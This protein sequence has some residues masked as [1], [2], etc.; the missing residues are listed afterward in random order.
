MS[1]FADPVQIVRH[2]P[3]VGWV[4]LAMIWT[5][6]WWG[7][8]I[9]WVSFNSLMILPLLFIGFGVADI[10]ARP[11]ADV[12]GWA[13]AALGAFPLGF[14]TAPCPVTVDRRVG[15]LKLPASLLAPMRYLLIFLVRSELMISEQVHPEARDQLLLATCIFAG[16]VVGY[17][18]GWCISLLDHYW[19]AP[20]RPVASGYY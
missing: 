4:F 19:R 17:Y 11:Q 9:H 12:L 7:M 15:K 6:A 16:A 5:R 13:A 14:R 1:M 3:T 10:Y 8:R 2:M 20:P 18:I